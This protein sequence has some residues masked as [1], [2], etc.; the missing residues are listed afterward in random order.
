MMIKFSLS[1]FYLIF[2]AATVAFIAAFSTA[3]TCR[4][5]KGVCSG[6]NTDNNMDTTANEAHHMHDFAYKTENG[7][8]CLENIKNMRDISSAFT[9]IQ[10]GRLYRTDCVSNASS[11]D[12][13]FC[14]NS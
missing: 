6:V 7:N 10:D 8:I 3:N 5:P 1:M 4:S 9:L 12:V 2:C 14:N 11:T 13:P